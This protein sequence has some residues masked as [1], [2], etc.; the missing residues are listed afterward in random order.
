MMFGPPDGDSPNTQQSMDWGIKRHTNDELRQR[1]VDMTVPQ[2]EALGVTLPDPGLRWN[3]ERGH[4]DFSEPD[5]T[6]FKAVI[7]GSGPCNAQRLAHRR[8]AHEDGAWVREAAQAYAAKHAREEVARD[9]DEDYTAEGGH[10]AVPTEGVETGAG[11]PTRGSWPLYEVFVRGKRGLNHVHVGSLHAADAEMALHNARDLYTRRNEGVSIWVVKA[12]RHHRVQPG[13]RR[14]RSSP[15]PPTRSTGTRRSTRSPRRCRTCEHAHRD[16]ADERLPVAGRDASGTTTRAGRSAPASRTSQAEITSPV[17]DGV[18]AGRPGRVLPDA[19]R[20][21]A[22]LQPPARGVGDA[23]PRS[24]RRRSRSPTS[25][26]TCSARPGC[27]WPAPAH[28]E[29]GRTGRGR[30]GLPARRGRS[31]ATSRSPS[32]PTTC[33][34]ARAIARLLLFSTWRLAL[35]HRLLDSRDPVL[36]AVAGKGVKELTYHRDYAARWTLRLGDGTARVAPA[37]A[38]RARRGLALRRGAVPHL[39]RGA[40]AGRRR[41][42]GRP[43]A[44]P[45]GGRRA[46]STRCSPA[47]P[48]TRPT[49]PPAGTDRRPRRPAGP[50]HR[51][52]RPRARRD[53]EPGPPAP[54]GDVVSRGP[55]RPPAGRTSRARERR[56]RAVVDPEMPMLTLDDL[57][58]RPRRRGRRGRGHRDDHA[59]LLRLPGASR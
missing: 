33:D 34:F 29:G 20:R 4:Y 31:S 17:P 55:R 52:P 27:C 35:L 3:A 22:D 50:A 32:C 39:R 23:T 42:G 18:D 45:R 57:G 15:R 41:G 1:F 37:D 28:V 2:A 24:W 36:A 49:V 38:G 44:D 7:S 59:D 16:D 10:G 12:E 51:A 25:R 48:S 54:G 19:R 5:W 53:A 13:R 40:P 9:D 26:S 8:R 46:C 58:R 14:T 11:A 30:A 56:S 43:G 6:E 21:R 47:P